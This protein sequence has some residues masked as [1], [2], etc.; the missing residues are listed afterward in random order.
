MSSVLVAAQGMAEARPDNPDERSYAYTW[1]CSARLHV[2]AH[3]VI[4]NR[5]D[6]VF[7]GSISGRN[8]IWIGDG[9]P[10]R[11]VAANF[12][13]SVGSPFAA[14]GNSPGLNDR[15]DVAFWAFMRPETCGGVAC[16]GLFVLEGDHLRT[17]VDPADPN[18]IFQFGGY[19][20]NADLNDA[21]TVAFTVYHGESISTG[22][23]SVIKITRTG[24]I[25]TVYDAA[26]PRVGSDVSLDNA[27]HVAFTVEDVVGDT[28]GPQSLLVGR[29]PDQLVSIA[30][31]PFAIPT[32]RLGPS[33]LNDRGQI[34]YRCCE[35]TGYDAIYLSDGRSTTLVA[36]NSGAFS[37]L[38][39][40]SINNRGTV[41]F[42]ATLRDGSRGV[43]T[44]PDPIAD[45]VI[46]SGDVVD[47]K[48]VLDVR[49]QI[50]F[51]NDRGQIALVVHF[52]DGDDVY[53]VDPIR[54]QD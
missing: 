52:S 43:F 38:G 46:G 32:A 23:P 36:D 9:G 3:P 39:T 19:P 26:N 49:A 12:I 42:L 18:D 8:T 33:F 37:S 20:A 35:E 54:R 31:S 48:V 25:T 41:A 24:K 5:G 30:D 50:R 45:R 4:N 17:V 16:S 44:G 7:T 53:R 11:V 10:L 13:A 29:R 51:L 21:G 28:A 15:G 40:L 47:G 22:L 34:A 6:V 14:F 1:I 2:T 27:G